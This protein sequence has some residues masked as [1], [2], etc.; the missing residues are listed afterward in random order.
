MGL[1][2]L[3]DLNPALAR[4]GALSVIFDT[5]FRWLPLRQ[6]H[7]AALAGY[8]DTANLKRSTDSAQNLQTLAEP[9]RGLPFR[10]DVDNQV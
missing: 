10:L 9:H 1:L 8:L 3:G 6:N 2:D 7:P 5:V 4:L